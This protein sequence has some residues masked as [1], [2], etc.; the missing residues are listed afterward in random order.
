[1]KPFK[2]IRDAFRRAPRLVW[3]AACLLLLVG[4]MLVYAGIPSKPTAAGIVR[5][6]GQPMLTG[7]IRFVPLPGT[8]GPDAGATVEEGKYRVEKGLTV[9][10][11]RVEIQGTRKTN[12][13][14][15]PPFPGEWVPEEVPTVAA[16]YDANSKLT[17]RI[18]AG[19]NTID[20]EVE[21]VKGKGSKTRK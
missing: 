4:A 5:L 20:F 19:A 6:D 3:G 15:Q 1:M 21:G 10:E 18:H 16:E 2:K 11:Y 8:S 13:M 17:A 12:K 9:G 7:R 14:V